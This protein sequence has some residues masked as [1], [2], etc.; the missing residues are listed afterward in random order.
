MSL[1]SAY[2][3]GD[4]IGDIREKL[5]VSGSE[6]YP[7]LVL[8]VEKSNNGP[9]FTGVDLKTPGSIDLLPTSIEG[10][11]DPYLPTLIAKM[12]LKFSKKDDKRKREEHIKKFHEG[13]SSK[14]KKLR[15]SI[16]KMRDAQNDS[17]MEFAETV[18]CALKA[19]SAE[20]Q[21]A[22]EIVRWAEESANDSQ[23]VNG[24]VLTLSVD[25][26]LAEKLIDVDAYLKST[27]RVKSSEHAGKKVEGQGVCAWC[28]RFKDLSPRMDYWKPGNIDNPFS[29]PFGRKEETFKVLPICFDCHD[30]LKAGMKIINGKYSSILGGNV[31]ILFA[32][33][34]L[35]AV[36]KTELQNNVLEFWR[37]LKEEILK[38]VQIGASQLSRR[39]EKVISLRGIKTTV[40]DLAD[41]LENECLTFDIMWLKKDN[42][43]ETVLERAYDVVPTWLLRLAEITDLTNNNA[44]NDKWSRYASVCERKFSLEGKHFWYLFPPP[45]KGKT[46]YVKT[47]PLKTMNLPWVVAAE[48]LEKRARP[49]HE[50]L[51]DFFA[52]VDAYW[53]NLE[54]KERKRVF[55]KDGFGKTEI[56]KWLFLW[57]KFSFNIYLLRKEIGGMERSESD[58]VNERKMPDMA[59]EVGMTASDETESYARKVI[60]AAVHE[61][62][63]ARVFRSKTEK[64][65]F[66]TGLAL[67]M[68]AKYQDLDG[69]TM[70]VLDFPGDYRLGEIA[71]REF[72]LRFGDKLRDYLY[73]KDFKESK[74]NII[75]GL[76]NASTQ[77]TE[78]GFNELT[79]EMV[80][81][82]L[83]SG[84]L[85][86]NDYY[87]MPSEK[88]SNK[89]RK[90]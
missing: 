86:A 31:H 39:G 33:R 40:D 76:L 59:A 77:R 6:K 83:L 3:L 88:D 49:F 69:K 32:P 75:Q 27:Y 74:G 36:S 44:R 34:T 68:L 35:H 2:L 84:V 43:A 50:Y 24:F 37:Q 25:G 17:I 60:E 11:K 42:S 14:I 7:I 48:I 1:E 41:M 67:G 65:I 13:L 8:R 62:D 90:S 54:E 89:G 22:E 63:A 19:D 18:I 55:S 20:N 56:G 21:I 30:C 9:K 38:H 80:G 23:G 73:V 46:Q 72:M 71:Y 57:H 85:R 51:P 5:R 52:G 79:P 64:G 53:C 82:A 4:K 26:K 12:N 61:A 45:A 29:A 70:R 28:E 16:E 58:S 87:F 81:F 66:L 47:K 10:K 78:E 15:S